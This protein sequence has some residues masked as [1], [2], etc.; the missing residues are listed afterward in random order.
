MELQ[1]MCWKIK[2][3]CFFQR[4]EVQHSDLNR[5]KLLEPMS[6][7]TRTAPKRFDDEVFL[8]GANNKYTVGRKV[9]AGHEADPALGLSERESAEIRSVERREKVAE[10]NFIVDDLDGAADAVLDEWGAEPAGDPQE[11]R[12]AAAFLAYRYC[13]EGDHDACVC[14]TT[15]QCDLKTAMHK[16]LLSRRGC[17]ARAAHGGVGLLRWADQPLYD[18]DEYDDDEYD[19]DFWEGFTDRTPDDW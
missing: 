2:L 18:S 10:E 1:K 3:K 6:T 14:T 5:F 4:Y 11:L 12:L 13:Q 17:S 19:D 7:R 9:D 16:E 8:P 15:I